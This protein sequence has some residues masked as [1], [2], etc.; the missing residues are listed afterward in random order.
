MKDNPLLQPF[1]T[2]H[3]TVPFSKIKPEHFEPAVRAEIEKTRE[4]IRKIIDN[5]ETPTFENTVA[6]LDFAD[7]R[8]KRLRQILTNINSANTN[9]QWQAVS[10]KVMP[11][12][13]DFYSEL[14][15]N[16]ALFDRIKRVY[17]RR[18]ELT[19]NDEQSMLLEQTYRALVRNGV[20]LDKEKQETLRKINRRLT[21][22][23][24][25]F[26]KNL[27]HDTNE[28]Y[29]H[30]TDENQLAGL[31][32]R[33]V[34]AAEEEAAKRGK[35]GWIFTLHYPSYGPFMKNASMRPLRE[36]M[37]KLYGS[38]AFKGDEYDNRETVLEEVRLR[39][40]K[41][42]LLGYPSYAAY[43]LEERMADS[44][45]KVM[46]FLDELY[47]YAMPVARKET[48]QLRQL[49]K[50]DGVDT[51]QAWDIAYYSEKLKREKLQLDEEKLK[52]YF[53]LDKVVAGLFETARKLYGIRFEKAPDIDVYHP[54]V[55]AY[56]VLDADG[57]FLAV[58]YAD[59]F[60]REGKRQGAW[61]TSFNPQYIYNGKEV[62]PHISIV[63][64]FSKP[65]GDEP[66]LL[67][68]Y[69]VNTLFHE[70]GHALHGMLSKVTYPSLSGTNVYWDFVELP[71]QIMENWTYEPEVL[72]MISGHYQTGEPVP[73][74]YIEKLKREKQFLEGMA[75][76]RQLGFG[77]LDMAWHHRY[78]EDFE[79][80]VQ[81]E[82]LALDKIRL[83]PY[84]EGT[85]ISTSFGH[86]FAGGYA[87]GYYS[88]K[89]AELLDADAF[90]IFKKSGI[91]D[92]E[93][94][95][96]FR[97][98]L[99]QGGTRHPMELYIEFAGRRPKIDALLERAGFKQ[100]NMR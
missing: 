4:N 11:V 53:P 78:P 25:Q 100:S 30:I 17:D 31:P 81:Y 16:E 9:E 37:Y 63:T 6:A 65:T 66:S 90:S 93:T 3:E 29:L 74:E 8:L 64:N 70:F 77:Y 51:L 52:P 23:S 72:Q 79:N 58:F 87:A 35:E 49:A 92:K 28:Y 47:G 42:A 26:T 41:A 75:T 96:R 83:Y 22:L 99:E 46:A 86:L 10:E 57:S 89:W 12:I 19:L 82:N 21:E 27:L 84:V 43:V 38:R 45:E 40:Q 34:R 68:F 97:H 44:P 32:E 33:V 5:P 95:G 62:R 36:Q 48:E 13:S 56:R 88:Y 71:S 50:A 7:L 67:S 61:M 18:N 54:D 91:F 76:V 2:P 98:L 14:M 94:A 80:I 20:L 1:H 59:F 60:P 39:K 73:Q 69:E 15:Q 85:L 24:L 55:Q